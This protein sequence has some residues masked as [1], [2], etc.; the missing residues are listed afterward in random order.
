[1][2]HPYEDSG[3]FAWLAI[4]GVGFVAGYVLA[5]AKVLTNS[6]S[7]T[8]VTWASGISAALVALAVDT[9]TSAGALLSAGGRLG[10]FAIVWFVL[11]IVFA[12][13]VSMGVEKASKD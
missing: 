4:G 5:K 10:I 3:G 13:G 11:G 12:I 7:G 2:L 1:M 9:P 6:N 8:F